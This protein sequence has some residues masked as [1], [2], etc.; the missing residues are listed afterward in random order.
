MLRLPVVSL[1]LSGQFPHP[2]P[3]PEIKSSVNDVITH[4][5]RRCVVDVKCSTTLFGGVWS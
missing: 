5:L 3:S 4:T 2:I 1:S